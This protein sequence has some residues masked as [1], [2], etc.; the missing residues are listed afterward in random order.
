MNKEDSEKTAI[1]II[2]ERIFLPAVAIAGVWLI[3]PRL[4]YILL[5]IIIGFLILSL[6]STIDFLKKTS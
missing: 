6:I 5:I 1:R 4:P 2:S 3:T